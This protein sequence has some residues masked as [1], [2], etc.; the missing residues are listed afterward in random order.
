MPPGAGFG[1]TAGAP[2][3]A[4]GMLSPDA[5]AAPAPGPPKEASGES[6]GSVTPEFH[7][8]TGP[9]RVRD[10]LWDSVVACAG[11]GTAVLAYPSNNEQGFELR[12]VGGIPLAARRR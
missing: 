8:G 2:N 11:D 5:R 3:P 6:L 9:A 10:G 1:A 12:T 4:P 7:V